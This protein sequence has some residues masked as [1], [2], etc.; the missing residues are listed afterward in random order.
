MLMVVK[1]LLVMSIQLI[2]AWFLAPTA[3]WNLRSSG[4]LP[5][6]DLYLVADVSGQPIG[7]IFRG[8]AVQEE[9]LGLL[10][11]W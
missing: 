4:M 5:V 1:R 8:Q 11:I 2:D 6:V 9:F 10:D 3:V 7:R